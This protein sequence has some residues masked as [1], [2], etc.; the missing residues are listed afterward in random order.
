M[1]PDA[2]ILEGTADIFCMRIQKSGK[3]HVP[4]I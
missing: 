1:E 3:A 4:C 2:E